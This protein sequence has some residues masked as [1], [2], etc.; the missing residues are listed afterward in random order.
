MSNTLVKRDKMHRGRNR[1]LLDR[2]HSISVSQ[3]WCGSE[4]QIKLQVRSQLF[5]KSCLVSGN[6]VQ[7]LLGILHYRRDVPA[8]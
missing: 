7:T 4:L 2:L 6:V 1:P 3:V 8:N 5:E